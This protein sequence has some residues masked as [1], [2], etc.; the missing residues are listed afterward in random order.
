[1]FRPTPVIIR[2]SSERILMLYKIYAFMSRLCFGKEL[3]SVVG[4]QIECESMQ[5]VL[6]ENIHT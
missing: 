4:L 5:Q 1:M 3:F 2:F 6:T